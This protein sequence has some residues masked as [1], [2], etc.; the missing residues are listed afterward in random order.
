MTCGVL[1]T[2]CALLWEIVPVN[3]GQDFLRQI[4]GLFMKGLFFSFVCCSV[5]Q[6][7]EVQSDSCWKQ[8]KPVCWDWRLQHASW[9]SSVTCGDEVQCLMPLVA[10]SLADVMADVDENHDGEEDEGWERPNQD[11]QLLLHTQPDG[12]LD[13]K[14]K[15]NATGSV[16]SLVYHNQVKERLC[17]CCITSFPSP[18]AHNISIDNFITKPQIKLEDVTRTEAGCKGR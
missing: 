16:L 18:S 10:D 6:H 3:K 8:K 9:Q 1:N 5:H 11:I 4:L 13:Q 2:F 7:L 15:I 17:V 12:G 14:I